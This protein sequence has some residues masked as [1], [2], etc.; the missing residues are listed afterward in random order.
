MHWRAHFQ[1]RKV[2]KNKDGI[3]N[4][5]G[6]GGIHSNKRIN[7]THMLPFEATSVGLCVGNG[8][9]N[10]KPTKWFGFQV[11]WKASKTSSKAALSYSINC[12]SIYEL[13]R[14][15]RSC[16]EK[17]YEKVYLFLCR[18]V[19][20]IR[21]FSIWVCHSCP[22]VWMFEYMILFLFSG[23]CNTRLTS[24]MAGPSEDVTG[25]LLLIQLGSISAQVFGDCSPGKC[26][27]LN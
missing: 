19:H 3:K 10:S 2:N 15:H 12:Q 1:A 5:E 8:K 23:Y 9:R 25:K 20:L 27:E 11:A 26:L 4:A 17:R 24:C 7:N 22:N 13:I 18:C 14:W 21:M 16:S 6:G